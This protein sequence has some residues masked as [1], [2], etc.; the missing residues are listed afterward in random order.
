VCH[1][2]QGR[3]RNNIIRRYSGGLFAQLFQC[4][5]TDERGHI[6]SHCIISLQRK[7]LRLLPEGDHRTRPLTHPAQRLAVVKCS[8]TRRLASRLPLWSSASGLRKLHPNLKALKEK[9]SR[10]GSAKKRSRKKR[11]ANLRPK[12]S[13]P[14]ESRDQN[15]KARR[16]TRFL[17]KK[18][19]V[20][21][22]TRRL[23]KEDKAA[24]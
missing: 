11:V 22:Q 23:S 18:R 21:R 2:P 16:S 15:L 3:E 12:R 14:D 5:V 19:A 1:F 13:R 4:P 6:F 10:R 17:S 20:Q 7:Q 24:M 8:A 9:E